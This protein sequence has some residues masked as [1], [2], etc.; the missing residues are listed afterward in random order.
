MLWGTVIFHLNKLP[1]NVSRFFLAIAQCLNYNSVSSEVYDMGVSWC[2][3]EFL[4][5]VFRNVSMAVKCVQVSVSI[6]STMM[7]AHCEVWVSL[8]RCSTSGIVTQ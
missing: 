7:V 1:N 2:Q 4:C 3:L 6:V 5:S 8:R